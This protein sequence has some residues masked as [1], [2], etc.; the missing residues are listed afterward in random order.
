MSKQLYFFIDESGDPNLYG[1]GK[2]PLWEKPDFE[3]MLMLGMVVVE[4]RKALRKKIIDFQNHILSDPLFN[5][6]VSK[7][8]PHFI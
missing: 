2:I 4:N 5:E 1:K 6:A 8:Q 3:P 7:G